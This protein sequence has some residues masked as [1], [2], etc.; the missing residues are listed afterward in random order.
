MIEMRWLERRT[1]KNIMNEHGWLDA[2]VVTVLQ[3][4]ERRKVMNM[5]KMRELGSSYR[6]EVWSNWMDVPTVREEE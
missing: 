2:E 5:Q 3:Y 1:G 4:R 6:E